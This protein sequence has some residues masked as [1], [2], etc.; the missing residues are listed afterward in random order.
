MTVEVGEH[1]LAAFQ[2][3]VEEKDDGDGFMAQFGALVQ[4]F[5]NGGTA[6]LP[7]VDDE[8]G[9]HGDTE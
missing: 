1:L 3:D 8:A 5:D 4:G 6:M 2:P 7:V 9:F